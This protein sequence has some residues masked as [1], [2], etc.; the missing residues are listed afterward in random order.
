VVSF[1]LNSTPYYV[2]L[3]T[4]PVSATNHQVQYHTKRAVTFQPVNLADFNPFIK[5]TGENSGCYGRPKGCDCRSNC[6]LLR[7]EWRAKSLDTYS[8]IIN[9]GTEDSYLAIG[10]PTAG[11]MGP[12]PVVVCAKAG[13]LSNGQQTAI[14]WN[15][16][17]G[18]PI[19]V[20]DSSP[21]DLVTV[22]AVDVVDGQLVCSLDLKAAFQ[23]KT[24]GQNT[25]I[26]TRDLN[27]EA[28]FV[29]LAT[30]PLKEGELQQHT[31]RGHTS[32][33][34]WWSDYNSFLPISYHGC[35]ETVGCEGLPV[36][37]ISA[38]NCSVL[39]R[40]KAVAEESYQLTLTGTAEDSTYLAFGLSLDEKMGDDSV[41]ACIPVEGVGVVM[42]WN[43]VGNSIPL[44]NMSEGVSSGT[45]IL[46]DGVLS[47]TF[48]LQGVT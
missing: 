32:S 15:P 46:E 24:D 20:N 14:Y 40:Y 11:E 31:E 6:T 22:V 16:P 4:G 30:G 1:D 25:S 7:A 43:K 36:G 34:V 3:A 8:I 42:Y 28:Y 13:G 27:S 39:L 18:T 17:A 10:F 41:V 37:C 35:N 21:A 44:P 26:I 23:I 5:P 45:A 2:M 48:L 9:G 38:R 33:A 29:I 19:L 12:A 47:C